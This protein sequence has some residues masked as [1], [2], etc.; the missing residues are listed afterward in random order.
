MKHKKCGNAKFSASMHLHEDDDIKTVRYAETE[1][2]EKG[3]VP[4]GSDLLQAGGSSDEEFGRG[5][6]DHG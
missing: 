5:S 3:V 1:D 6:P 2:S 4:A